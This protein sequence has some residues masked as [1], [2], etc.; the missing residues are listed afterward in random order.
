MATKTDDTAD[1]GQV[2]RIRGIVFENITRAASFIGV[3]AL[4]LLLVYTMLDA[5]QPQTASQEWYLLVGGVF[6]VPTLLAAGYGWRNRTA[7]TVALRALGI[8]TGAAVVTTALVLWLGSQLTVVMFVVAIFPTAATLVYLYT[9]RRALTVG[10]QLV[11]VIVAGGGVA[12]VLALFLGTQ[13]TL[14]AA[15][16]VGIPAA[17]LLRYFLA[18]PTV[19]KRGVV[20]TVVAALGAMLAAVVLEFGSAF[21]PISL[22]ERAV[23]VYALGA[24][25]AVAVYAGVTLRQ[26]RSGQVGLVVPFVFIAGVLVGYLFHRTYVI[27]APVGPML[28]GLTAGVPA[29]VF[30]AMVY[31]DYDEG[32]LGL[33]LPVV[34]AIGVAAGLAFHQ[35]FIVQAPNTLLAFGLGIGAAYGGYAAYVRKTDAEGQSGL[36]LSV[37][38]IGSLLV[39]ILAERRL[40]LAGP[41]TW[42]DVSF[43]TS[44]SHY[45]PA[46]TGVHPALVGSLYLMFIVAFVAFP[47][48]VGTAIYLEEYAPDNRWKRLLEVNI[49]NLA[50]VPSVV[51]GLLGV[52]VFV[53]YGG[54][55]LGAI[56]AGGFTLALLIL[57]IVIISSQEAIR[58]VPDSLRQ[59]SYGMGATRWQT[60]R[61]VVLP[62]AVP[63]ILTGTILALGRAVGETA[64][65]LMVGI[66]AV[67]GMPGELTGQGTALPLQVFSWSLDANPILRE[68]VAAAGAMTLLIVL[69]SMNALA[70]VIRNRYEQTQ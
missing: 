66:A 13:A 52:G 57:P 10:L 36:G 38:V 24:V 69:L 60:V 61:N 62:R 22:G 54:L 4:F 18:N 33:A 40:G 8:V 34:A 27:V 11:G 56:V 20:A 26:N 43:L 65:L 64:P 29:L 32:Q 2:S 47:L 70:I 39:A 21:V 58:A 9:R 15:V 48:G 50:G 12:S 19:G 28:Y 3:F 41:D 7:G 23:A 46:L 51:Y 53:R 45:K 67:G 63:G 44:G 25:L 17:L 42:L 14:V 1:F 37:V 16:T 35:R 31:R 59:A 68:N 5:F 6:G 49:S 30:A 55:S